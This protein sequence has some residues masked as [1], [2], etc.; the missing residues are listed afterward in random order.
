MKARLRQTPS[1]QPA[2]LYLPAGRTHVLVVMDQLTP[3]GRAA[4]CAPLAH[5]DPATTAILAP[6]SDLDLPTDGEWDKVVW[7][8]VKGPSTAQLPA[9]IQE[10]ISLGS[11]MGLGMQAARWAR[12]HDIRHNVVQ[13]GLLTPWSPPAAD[14]D[15]L[16]A[17]TQEDADYWRSGNSTVTTEVV[18]SQMLWAAA[19]QPP[20]QLLDERA[21]MLGQLHGIELTKRQTFQTYWRFCRANDV[22]YRPHPNEVDV[23][24]RAAHTVMRRGGITFEESGRSLVDL[25]R[26][27]VSIF[28]TGSLEAAHRGLPA[29]VYHPSPPE[30]VRDFW[31]R[32]RLSQWGGSPTPAW[33]RPD[34]EPADAI[35]STVA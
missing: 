20:A 8:R 14:G 32:Y 4:V 21:V 33:H 16:L 29:F 10:V 25:G 15:R 18:G 23:A 17:W 3:S 12:Q 6:V 1:D 9:T 11:Y 22:D 28:S 30:W 7:D 27:V 5:L 35:A 34:R 24:S 19:H 13:H 26:P 31:S 2:T